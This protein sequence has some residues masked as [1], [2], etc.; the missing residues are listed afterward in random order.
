[1]PSTPNA[2]SI[3]K[4]RR[5]SGILDQPQASSSPAET[6][7]SRTK[8]RAVRSRSFIQKLENRPEVEL[9]QYGTVTLIHKKLDSWIDGAKP[10]ELYHHYSWKHNSAS[11]SA[12]AAGE[13]VMTLDDSDCDHL[14]RR[15]QK[16]TKQRG[17][18]ARSWS[19]NINMIQRDSM[20]DAAPH[21]NWCRAQNSNPTVVKKT[22]RTKPRRFSGD[23]ANHLFQKQSSTR[24]CGSCTSSTSGTHDLT[25]SPDHSNSSSTEE[26]QD[27]HIAHCGIRVKD[28]LLDND[29]QTVR[30]VVLEKKL[31]SRPVIPDPDV[32]G[33]G[34]V[35]EILKRKDELQ[36]EVPP[37]H[38]AVTTGSSPIPTRRH[39]KFLDHSSSPRRGGV[40]RSTSLNGANLMGGLRHTFIMP[41]SA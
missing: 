13:D 36:K 21:G 3:R 28:V 7:A 37:Y 24:S 11:G 15:V 2:T 23:G 38:K 18:L 39:K 20:I 5:G 27:A 33:E 1:M 30:K 40:Q 14:M 35:Q 41:L 32:L 29:I 16:L 4:T 25:V 12:A 8:L 31:W 22:H 17:R 26:P 10:P 34:L 9:L 6:G 19:G